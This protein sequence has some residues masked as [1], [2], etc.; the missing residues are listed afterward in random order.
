MSSPARSGRR[1]PM[2]G[3]R[4]LPAVLIASSIVLLPA[5]AAISATDP[6]TTPTTP[7]T[8]PTPTPAPNPDPP[9][10][11]TGTAEAI[12]TG[13]ATLTGT[14]SANGSDTSY[15]FEYGTTSAYGLTTTAASVAASASNTTVKAPVTGLTAATTYHVR[16][17]ATNAAGTVRGSDRTFTT[18]SQG[19]APSV[20]TQAASKTASTSATLNARVS[21]QGQSTTVRFDWGLTKAYGNTTATTSAGSS[22]GTV[23]RGIGVGSLAAGTTYHYRAVAQNAAG[24]RYGSDRTFTTTRGL[25]KVTAKASGSEISWNGSLN[26]SGQVSGAKPGGVKLELLRQDFPYNATWR[27]IGTTTTSS[28]GSYNVRLQK[29]FNSVNVRVRVI[30]STSL[31]SPA[32]RVGS[33]ILVKITQGVRKARTSRLRGTL[34]P[35]KRGATA[36]LQR[37]TPSGRWVRVRSLRLSVRT[38]NRLSYKTVVRR[39]GRDASYRVVADPH[40]GGNHVT[41]TSGTV[42]VKARKK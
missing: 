31:V 21:P 14:L 30:G 15:Q 18:S 17:V 12:G 29:A 7:V 37:Q 5:G 26:V 39:I 28:T 9:K 19:K 23:S 2:R 20:S 22:K 24:V 36:V 27:R 38:N 35:A 25:T 13:G 16:L 1:L 33:Q 11:T 42:T 6:G 34:F 41:T 40:D 8:T 32:I 3:V 4:S 10:V